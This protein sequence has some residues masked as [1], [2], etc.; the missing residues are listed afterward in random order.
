MMT[1]Q[2]KASRASAF[3]NRCI[4]HL[5]ALAGLWYI[6]N[7]AVL[8]QYDLT[9]ERA[10]VVKA[11]AQAIFGDEQSVG[12]QAAD[13]NTDGKAPRNTPPCLPIIAGGC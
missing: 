13:Q 6:A 8:W 1:E 5:F 7:V 12:Q 11:N 4:V 2:T 10:F 3:I 9:I